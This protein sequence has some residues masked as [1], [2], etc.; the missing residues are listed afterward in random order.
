[1]AKENA[2]NNIVEVLMLYRDLNQGDHGEIEETLTDL[3]T[4]IQHFCTEQNIDFDE[5]T[6]KADSHFLT[7]DND[8]IPIE[9]KLR[10]VN[11]S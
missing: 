6:A 10:E 5:I 1:M 11:N 2:V 8:E 9:E 7:E 3:L 4:D